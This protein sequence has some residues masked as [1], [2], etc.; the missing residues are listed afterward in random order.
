M[1][2]ALG[3]GSTEEAFETAEF[4]AFQH[5]VHERYKEL[6]LGYFTSEFI[7]VV[8]QWV[9]DRTKGLRA[10]AKKNDKA[11]VFP[12]R[13]SYYFGT[14]VSGAS[15]LVLIA[16]FQHINRRHALSPDGWALMQ[17]KRLFDFSSTEIH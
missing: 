12:D 3:F 4:E 6:N 1:N 5:F 2:I 16:K 8:E 7:A 17:S 10:E 9:E 14:V 13:Y 11:E 15:D